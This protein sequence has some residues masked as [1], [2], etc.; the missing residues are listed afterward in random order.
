V[1]A[2]AEEVKHNIGLLNNKLTGVVFFDLT[3]AF[4]SVNWKKLVYKLCHDF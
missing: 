1:L 2:L 3:D 4:G